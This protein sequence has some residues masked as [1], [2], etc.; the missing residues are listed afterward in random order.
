MQW[1]PRDLNVLA[2]DISK[3]VDFDDYT[4]ND[5]VF[6]SLDELWGPHTW[7][8][9]ACHYNAKLPKFN[10]RYYQ[11]GSSGVNA[12]VQDWYYDNN[13]LRP[14]VRLTCKVVSHMKVCNV[15]GTLVVP[16]WKS[17]HF[18]PRLCFDGLHW[19]GF[20]HDYIMLPDLPNLFVR[21]KAKNSIFGRGPLAFSLVTLRID[22]SI[23][24]KQGPGL[25]YNWML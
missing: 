21:G 25:V 24:S 23:A 13:W 12:F 10:T 9:F 6:F 20:V 5:E 1:I 19:N 18:W 17:A 15:A 14:P 16:L 4:I 22:F 8:R 11:P 7:D 3:F 2:D